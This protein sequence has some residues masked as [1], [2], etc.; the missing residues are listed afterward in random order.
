MKR[1]LS[2][3][4]LM[5]IAAV[6]F[7]TIGLFRRFIPL[8][9]GQVALYRAVMAVSMLGGY[10]LLSRPI[11]P[12]PVIRRAMP[13][14]LLSGAAMGF[15]WVLLFE[16]YEYTTLSAATLSYY[17][18]PVLVT[19]LCPM[20]FKEKMG[21]QQW[22]CFF[23]STLGLVLITSPGNPQEGTNHLLGISLGLGAAV[24]YALVILLN[25]KISNV[26]G[27]MRTF[28]QFSAAA[29]VLAPYVGLTDGFA[30]PRMDAGGWAALLAV[31]IF[32]TGIIYCLYFSAL[33]RLPGQE[34]AILSYLDPL[35]AVLIS[36]FFLHESL[37]PLQFIGGVMILGFTLWNEIRPAAKKPL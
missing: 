12:W 3:R 4:L 9:G 21:W 5:I 8:S 13:L 1:S 25:K 37:T 33:R 19:V 16:A 11:L 26:D 29:F 32:H 14:L 22:I 18:G 31:G 30:L 34:A 27:L 10:L 6:A 20:L 15:N 35:V 17:F 2:P 36:V 24:L 28:V 23:F 7:G